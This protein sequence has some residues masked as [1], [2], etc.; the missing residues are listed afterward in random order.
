M[1]DLLRTERDAIA[2]L[3]LLARNARTLVDI[4]RACN[5]PAPL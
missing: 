1:N 2:T 5:L 3:G 4:K